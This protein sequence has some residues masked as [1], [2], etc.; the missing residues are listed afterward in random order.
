M[1]TFKQEG[2]A[3]HICETTT[4]GSNSGSNN[5]K[6]VMFN[7]PLNYTTVNSMCMSVSDCWNCVDIKQYYITSSEKC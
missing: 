4:R 3:A 6:L 1:H 2:K 5:D 7:R